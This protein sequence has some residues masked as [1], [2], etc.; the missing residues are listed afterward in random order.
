[1]HRRVLRCVSRC[2]LGNESAVSDELD[3]LM[4]GLIHAGGG[5]ITAA[6]L[7]GGFMRWLNGRDREEREIKAADEAKK[8]REEFLE[9][10][11]DVK[12]L[13]EDVGEHKK[14]FEDVVETKLSLK[15]L[16]RRFDESE[17][18]IARLEHRKR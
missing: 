2:G 14:V 17:V 10:R 5:G 11:A 1:M 4:K 12:R 15:A 18:R 13:L 9:L 7:V 6:T 16:H 8:A 3:P